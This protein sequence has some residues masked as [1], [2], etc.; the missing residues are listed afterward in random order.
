MRA[1]AT[2][3][4]VFLLLSGE[5]FRS[6]RQGDQGTGVTPQAVAYQVPR[7]TLVNDMGVS[8]Q[9]KT[10]EVGIYQFPS[11]RIGNYTVVAEASGFAPSTQQGITVSIQQRYVADFTLKPSSVA[12][13]I[14]VTGQ[15]APL[16][17]QETSLGAVVQS[18]AINDLPLNRTTPSSL[19][20]MRV[21]FRRSRT[22]ADGLVRQLFG[23]WQ[24]Q[25][26]EQLRSMYN[27]PRGFRQRSMRGPVCDALQEFRVQTSTALSSAGCYAV[28]NASRNRGE[29][30]RGTLNHRNQRWTPNFRQYQSLIGQVPPNRLFYAWRSCAFLRRATGRPL[31]DYEGTIARQ[32]RPRADGADSAHATKQLQRHVDLIRFQA[33]PARLPRRVFRSVHHGSGDDAVIRSGTDPISGR[34]VTHRR[35]DPRSADPDW[36]N[37]PANRINQMRCGC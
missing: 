9:T 26:P 16:Q 22:R 19:S 35:R 23:Q 21:S 37:H 30:Y 8:F 31:L 33:A 10:N 13:T 25:L 4:A 11:I 29:Q 34:M 36:H 27:N 28:L 3:L 17:T 15:M 20:S 12:E 1:L 24:K 32:R 6:I 14:E 2:L 5:S 7:V 18:Q